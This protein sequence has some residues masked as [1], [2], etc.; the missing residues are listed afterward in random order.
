MLLS[1]NLAPVETTFVSLMTSLRAP[2][3]AVVVADL[4]KMLEVWSIEKS[5]ILYTATITAYARCRHMTQA[6]RMYCELKER[7]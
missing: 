6:M 2:E 5:E 7:G 1:S 3:H 4:W